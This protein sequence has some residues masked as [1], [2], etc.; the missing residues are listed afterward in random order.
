[1]LQKSIYPSPLG[2]ILLAGD[3]EAVTGL[4]FTDAKY[5][6]LG[7]PPDTPVGKTATILKAEEWLDIYFSGKEPDFLP[8]LRPAGS[9]FRQ[10]VFRLLRQIPRGQTVTYGELARSL[11]C[12]SAQAVGGAVGHNPISIMIPC[13]RVV[14]AEGSLTGYAGGLAR[15][16]RLLSLEKADLPSCRA[17]V[18][19]K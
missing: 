4:W 3:E 10:K 1:M 19:A 11:G 6:G 18:L 2:E 13:H 9:P 16:R 8:A 15:K 17:A 14:G 7:L 5:A 12:A